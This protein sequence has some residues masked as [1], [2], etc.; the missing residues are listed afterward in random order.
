MA[1]KASKLD[2]LY[3]PETVRRFFTVIIV[4]AAVTVALASVCLS[5]PP[6]ALGNALNTRFNIDFLESIS[7]NKTEAFA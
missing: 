3:L 2:T 4:R 6:L 5:E 7:G 1:R